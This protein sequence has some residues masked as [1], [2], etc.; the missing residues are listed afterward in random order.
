[1]DIKFYNPRTTWIFLVPKIYGS[2]VRYKLLGTKCCYTEFGNVHSIHLHGCSFVV[3][4][5]I[6]INLIVID[7]WTSGFLFA[8]RP[9]CL[10]YL[11]ML[12]LWGC[13]IEYILFTGPL[14]TL[15]FCKNGSRRIVESFL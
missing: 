4:Y 10:W 14:L 1:M 2:K 9:R 6:G 11:L 15:T 5:R 7:T 8:K 3:E 13:C 12:F